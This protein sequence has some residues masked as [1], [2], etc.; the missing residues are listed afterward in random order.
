M[1]ETVFSRIMFVTLISLCIVCCGLAMA[2]AV[3]NADWLVIDIFAFTYLATMMGLVDVQLR[4]PAT[5]EAQ[6][7]AHLD[8][9][10]LVHKA[11]ATA[12]TPRTPSSSIQ[13]DP[14]HDDANPAP[15]KDTAAP[16]KDCSDQED[17]NSVPVQD[18]GSAAPSAGGGEPP[19]GPAAGGGQPPP[20]PRLCHYCRQPGRDGEPVR[21][22]RKCR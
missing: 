5:E 13:T 22:C 16:V 7:K 14:D 18:A 20:A 17:A 12:R 21:L 8:G 2:M 4:N 15:V 9:L 10:A 1:R 6:E 3:R 11:L 19:P